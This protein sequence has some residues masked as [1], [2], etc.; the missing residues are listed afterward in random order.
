MCAAKILNMEKTS[1]APPSNCKPLDAVSAFQQSTMRLVSENV[2][3]KDELRID[4]IAR[5]HGLH[6]GHI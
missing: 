6:K 1:Q 2:A 5:K 3:Q 4:R